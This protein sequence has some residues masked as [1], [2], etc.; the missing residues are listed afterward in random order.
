MTDVLAAEAAEIAELEKQVATQPEPK[1][2]PAQAEPAA[3]DAPEPEPQDEPEETVELANKGRFVR[4]GEYRAVRERA[5]AAE[6]RAKELEARL[7]LESS[8][9]AERL[10]RLEQAMVQPRAQEPAKPEIQIPDV[11]TDPIGHFQAKTALLEQKLAEQESFRQ[12]SQQSSE[13][14]VTRQKIGAEVSRLEAEFARNVPDYPA[15]QEFLQKAWAAEGQLLGVPAQQAI[16]FYAEQVVRA[17]AAQN[18]NPG[19]LAYEYAK[20][21]GYAKAAAN[22]NGAVQP[23]RTGPTMETLQRGLAAAKSTSA[24]PG[25]A[26]PGVPTIDALL[27]MDDDEFAAKFAARD[28]RDWDKTMRKLM[29]A[30]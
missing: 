7:A 23:Q 29:G 26:A 14:D 17:A 11:N 2:E 22:G 16:R 18:K 13:A 24:A 27:K 25:N 3:Q 6:T 28:S 1:P 8:R 15:A 10:A 20:A 4:Q 12:K 5:T 30:A 9:A 21:R 19:E